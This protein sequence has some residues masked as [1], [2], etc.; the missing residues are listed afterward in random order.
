MT[1]S[2][3]RKESGPLSRRLAAR[4]FSQARAWPATT[5]NS[6]QRRRAAH[7][8]VELSLDFRIVRRLQR[9]NA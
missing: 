5:R 3:S 4:N 8:A 6:D 7:D 2:R 1:I 9:R